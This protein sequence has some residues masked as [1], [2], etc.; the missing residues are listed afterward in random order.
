MNRIVISGA[1]GDLGR[2]VTKLLLKEG[3]GV[4][5]TLVTRTPEKL[6]DLAAQGIRVLK[7]DYQDPDSLDAAYSGADTLF[8]ISGLNLGWRISE[9]RNAI[10]AAQ[11]ALVG[12]VVYTS[13]GGVAAEQPRFVS[14]GSLPD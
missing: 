10:S 3:P 9:H 14:Q 1:S 2:R 4:E 12:H 11:R 7:G 13:V 6:A 8:L 5:L